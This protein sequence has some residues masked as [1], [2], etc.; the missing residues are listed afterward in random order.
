MPPKGKPQPKKKQD[1][2][3]A[4]KSKFPI[5]TTWQ[6]A[7]NKVYHDNV[8][9]DV[10]VILKKW[11]SIQDQAA[12][13]QTGS[14]G[15]KGLVGLGSPFEPAIY[16]ERQVSGAR[17]NCHTNLFH[18]DL[19]RS[20]LSFVPLY[21]ERVIELSV[22]KFASP[23][24]TPDVSLLADFPDGFAMPKGSLIRL[25]PCEPV[26]AVLHRVSCRILANAPES[27]LNDWLRLLLS[28]PT[29]FVQLD[30]DEDKYAEANSLREDISSTAQAVTLT[31]RQLVHNIV[32]FKA[33]KEAES[34]QKN[35]RSWS[36]I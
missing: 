36:H 13:P 11:P 16:N 8:I 2:A 5:L 33:I 27:E 14:A 29:R 23:S 19:L 15:F 17:Y 1:V 10:A 22:T 26:H 4:P 31:C 3:V 6:S 7:V 12:L 35:I 24:Q 25:S 20:V 34:K 21:K 32:G 30:T 9:K 28:C 18:Q